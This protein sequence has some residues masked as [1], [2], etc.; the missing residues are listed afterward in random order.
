MLADIDL[1]DV[2][3]KD[4]KCAT[5]KQNVD[6][7]EKTDEML[8]KFGK[9]TAGQLKAAGKVDEAVTALLEVEK[10]ARLGG[11]GKSTL[12][13]AVGIVEML[14]AV[15]DNEKLMANV[16]IL[17]KRRAQ[18]KH[19]QLAVI[20]CAR[21]A[22]DATEDE[23][24]RVPLLKQLR[25][26]CQGKLHVEYEFAQL[27][28]EL[29]GIWERQGKLK[30]ST[31]LMLDV[32]VETIGNMPRVEK[33]EI[34]LL[35]IRLNLDV[36]DYIRAAIMARKTTARALTKPNSRLIKMRYYEMMVRYY[37]HFKNYQFIAK[38]WMEIYAHATDAETKK[39]LADHPLVKD[40][41]IALSSVLLYL[42]LSSHTAV[43]DADQIDCAAFSLWNKEVDRVKQLEH[44]STQKLAQDIPQVVSLADAFLQKELIHW[45]VFTKQF[46]AVQA[47]HPVFTQQKEDR[48]DVLHT[49]ITEH[50]VCVIA[51]HYSKIRLSRLAS[52]IDLPADAAEEAVCRLVTEKTIWARVDRIGGVVSFAKAKNHNEVMCD[53]KGNIDHVLAKI[54]TACH[55]IDKEQLMHGFARKA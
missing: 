15:G 16:E 26:I 19:V 41:T 32:Q 54:T 11:D 33:L 22:I 49:R 35:Q 50:N 9:E 20:R 52:L 8:G 1:G 2:E 7:T 12:R 23:A 40:P 18:A 53:M 14:I 13:L 39:D 55:L 29:A 38:C 45:P 42:C 10:K 17:M 48:W 46:A 37:S 47:Q 31:Q 5:F 43:K 36:E 6:L 34:L 27:S 44:Y 4:W 30:D 21:K 28:V 3:E 25:D 51:M 24:T